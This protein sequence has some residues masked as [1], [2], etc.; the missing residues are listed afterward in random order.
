M[1][2]KRKKKPTW[3]KIYEENWRLCHEI[4][5]LRDGRCCQI[6]GCRE[7]ERLDL[8]HCISRNCKILFFETENLGYLCRDHHS[9]KS[10][11]P[12]QWVDKMVNDICRK[13]NGEAWWEDALFNSR[14]TCP[15]FST[16]AYQEKINEELKR[17]LELL[18]SK[19]NVIQPEV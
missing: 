11:R 2:K 6:P 7:T 5:D 3:R 13:R 15:L 10:F 16:L 14:K 18:K 4:V 19:T 1:K 9:H 17:E 12:N 8:D